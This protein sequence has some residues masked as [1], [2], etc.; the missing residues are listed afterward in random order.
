MEIMIWGVVFVVALG[1]LIKGAD[2]VLESARKIGL[3]LGMSPFVVG[4]II[5]GFGT[6]TPELASSIFGMLEGATEIPAANVI[7]SNIANIL[8]IIGFS[9]IVAR[10]AFAVKKDLINLEIPLL[11]LS[12]LFFYGTIYDGIITFAECLFLLAGFAIYTAYSILHRDEEDKEKALAKPAGTSPKD[13]VLL[14]LGFILLIGGAKYLIDAVLAIST[15]AGISVGIITILA[16]A[17]GTSLPEL[18]VSAKAAM[19]KQ[20]DLALGNIY[21]S[22]IY[23]ALFIIGVSGFFGT[24][25]LD[26]ATLTLA[27]PMFLGTTF[28]FLISSISRR[29]YLWEGAFYLLIYALFVSKLFGWV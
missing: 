21:G 16:V 13:V 23:N 28:L 29:I 7:G 14:I 11:A 3:S 15:A 5:V 27:V 24:Q 17:V 8:L 18:I 19:A 22:N 25:K 12:T 4:V 2:W 20:A 1:A 10:G 26:E 9:A 6:S